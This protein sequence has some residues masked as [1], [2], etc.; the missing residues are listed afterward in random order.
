ME[1]VSD[2][3][4]QLF[5]DKSKV[6]YKSYHRSHPFADREEC[7]EVGYCCGAMEALV[8]FNNVIAGIIEYA[9]E[10]VEKSVGIEKQR[11]IAQTHAFMGVQK[12]LDMLTEGYTEE[13]EEV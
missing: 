12:I 7:F 11:C 13:K 2:N 6:E 3:M 8:F 1:K 5:A 10:N 4:L 9:K